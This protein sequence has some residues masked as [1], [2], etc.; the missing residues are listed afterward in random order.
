MFLSVQS[1]TTVWTSSP[2]RLSSEAE[3]AMLTV[4]C[5]CVLE[6]GPIQ[7]TASPGVKFKLLLRA[8]EAESARV[9][10]CSYFKT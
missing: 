9:A 7:P 8:S 1:F 10:T 2:N 6:A 4:Q 5:V 3:T